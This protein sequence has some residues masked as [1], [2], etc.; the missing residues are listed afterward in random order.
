VAGK[1]GLQRELV[2]DLGSSA[3]WRRGEPRIQLGIKA[4]PALL[5][6]FRNRNSFAFEIEDI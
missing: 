2:E 5:S 6:E 1:N 4:I 3:R